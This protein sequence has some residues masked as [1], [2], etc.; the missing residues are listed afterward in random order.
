MIDSTLR[1]VT[2]GNLP[3]SIYYKWLYQSPGKQLLNLESKGG[4]HFVCTLQSAFSDNYTTR[5]DCLTWWRPHQ[6]KRFPRAGMRIKMKQGSES[7][8]TLYGGGGRPDFTVFLSSIASLTFHKSQVELYFEQHLE[9][10]VSHAVPACNSLGGICKTKQCLT[11]LTR[12]RWGL[13]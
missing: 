8:I 10:S 3:I 9:K 6:L 4:F 2:L 13:H 7:I 12:P 1:N 5:T 11:N